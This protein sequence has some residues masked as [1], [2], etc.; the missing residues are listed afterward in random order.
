M[1]YRRSRQP[2]MSLKSD[3]D[4][5]EETAMGRRSILP[6]MQPPLTS[7]SITFPPDAFIATPERNSQ[8]PT[9]PPLVHSQTSSDSQSSGRLSKRLPSS[10]F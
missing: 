6:M 9:R 10:F 2:L 8:N 5:D 4:S 3:A 1:V 7:A